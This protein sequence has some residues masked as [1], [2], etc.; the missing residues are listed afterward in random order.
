M[1]R[2]QQAYL[3]QAPLFAEEH[4]REQ[5]IFDGFTCGSCSGNGWRLEG[6]SFRESKEV[7]CKTCKGS[8]RLKAVVTIEW[9]PDA[10]K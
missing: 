6:A 1:S 3:I 4:P 7:T 10:K 8:G 2:K 9:Q 5:E